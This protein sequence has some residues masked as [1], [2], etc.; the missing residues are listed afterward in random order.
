M[1][2]EIFNINGYIFW[3]ILIFILSIIIFFVL[4]SFST[5]FKFI[6]PN[7]KLEAI[8][9][10]FLS[11]KELNKVIEG[12]NITNFK[13]IVKKSINFDVKGTTIYEM[14]RSLD[15]H[16]I[17]TIEMIRK[18]SSKKMN[19]FFD[20]YLE[21]L[22]SF[23]IKNVIKKRLNN[24]KI[25]NKIIENAI[26][27]IT[28]KLLYKIT[29]SK[30]EDL[31]KILKDYSYDL[32]SFDF[33]S[34]ENVNLLELDTAFDKH[35]I[36]KFRKQ[37]VPRKCEKAKQKF[38]SYFI[39]IKNIKNILRAKQMGYDQ[40]VC[41]KLFLGEGHE[42]ADWRYKKMCESSSVKEII[43]SLA[44][45]SYYNLLSNTLETFSKENTIQILE[46]ALD[47]QF[48][49]FLRDLSVE[50]YITIGPTLRFIVS[51]EF[52]IRNLKVIV[53]GIGEGLSKDLIKKL[54]IAESA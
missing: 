30:K 22:D 8:G 27:P 49:K 33:K 31:I 51:K 37:K 48:L 41:N 39:D 26:K 17:Q 21:K 42:V 52:E 40:Q 9:N 4:R 45:T 3:I 13:D 7:A 32:E 5:Y 54:V 24:E 35:F 23:L 46:N 16:L 14:Q 36:N 44:E 6:Y 25:D 19:G 1:F 29:D 2:E 12:Q 34:V 10:P 38:V 50:N 53:K 15:T 43:S 28:K 20:L 47:V 18:D 11:E